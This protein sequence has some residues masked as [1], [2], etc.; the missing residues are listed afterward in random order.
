MRRPADLGGPGKFCR[1]TVEVEPRRSRTDLGSSATREM[2]HQV[3]R[4]VFPPQ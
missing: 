2:L 3:Q 1:P 4:I